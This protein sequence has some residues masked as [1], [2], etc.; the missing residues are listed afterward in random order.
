MKNIDAQ[1]LENAKRLFESGEIEKGEIGTTKGL[2][3]I[4]TNFSVGFTTLRVKSEPKIFQ[5]ERLGSPM[6]CI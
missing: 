2:Q 5:R 4:H 3:Q 6:R 1:S